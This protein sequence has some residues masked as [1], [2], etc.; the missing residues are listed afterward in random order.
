LPGPPRAR[1]PAP[2]SRRRSRK[3][4]S[5]GRSCANSRSPNGW[6]LARP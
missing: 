2:R 5:T 6:P 1:L 4:R 3:S